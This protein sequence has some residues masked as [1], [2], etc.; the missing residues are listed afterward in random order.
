MEWGFH[1]FGHF[2]HFVCGGTM[3]KCLL[4]HGGGTTDNLL[5]QFYKMTSQFAKF[6][7]INITRQVLILTE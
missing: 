4:T 5:T 6:D 2:V 3:G 1:R 7:I